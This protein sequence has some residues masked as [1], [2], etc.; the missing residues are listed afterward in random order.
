MSGQNFACDFLKVMYLKA[1]LP[2]C[3]GLCQTLTILHPP[4]VYML[5]EAKPV[6]FSV[7]TPVP[8]AYLALSRYAENI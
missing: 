1:N 3:T 2:I 7:G 6:A 4:P 8:N 5:Y